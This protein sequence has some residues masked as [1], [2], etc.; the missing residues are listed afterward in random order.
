MGGDVAGT[1][2]YAGLAFD[3]ITD[4]LKH[5]LKEINGAV[6]GRLCADQAATKLQTLAREDAGE[7]I[8][9]ALI[10]A[11]HVADLAPADTNIAGRYVNV[12]AHVTIELGHERL[13]EPHHFVVRFAAWVKVGAALAAAQRQPGEAVLEGLLESE[14][15]EHAF[16]NAGMEADTT[17]VGA[18]CV[19]VL[20]APA[21]LYA[22]VAFVIFPA[23]AEA[24]YPIGFGNPPQ[25]LILVVFFFVGDE[26]KN[27]FRDFLDRLLKL[28]LSRIALL[29]AFHELLEVDVVGNGHE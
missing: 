20:Y 7:A 6:A 27:V 2:Y 23:N 14:E 8:S 4:M 1:G 10:L 3:R 26:V 19:V 9:D 24:D 17:L 21:A 12:I 28:W 18:D 22:D 15:L 29:D 5:V 25:D 16:G 13:A 11:E